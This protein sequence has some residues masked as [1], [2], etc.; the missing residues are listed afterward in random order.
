MRI[1]TRR[2]S[3]VETSEPDRT[4]R[5]SPSADSVPP[6]LQAGSGAD[7]GGKLDLSWECPRRVLPA[8]GGI[9]GGGPF[10]FL[11]GVRATDGRG[12]GLL[13]AGRRRAESTLE[14]VIGSQRRETCSR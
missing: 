3:R 13:V 12:D 6:E 8:A 1:G 7:D 14:I 9:A 2:T 5:P 11:T 4:T 10:L